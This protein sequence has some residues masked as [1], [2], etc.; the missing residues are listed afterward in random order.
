MST[1]DRFEEIKRLLDSTINEF[2]TLFE[3]AGGFEDSRVGNG[4]SPE[5]IPPE[6]YYL[7]PKPLPELLKIA[8]SRKRTLFKHRVLSFI[9]PR[10]Q[11]VRGS[12]RPRLKLVPFW[13]VRG[14]HE[15]FYFRGNDYKID[16]P[17]DVIAVEVE[18]KIRDLVGSEQ[19]DGQGIGH[20]A[21]R[22]LGRKD[23]TGVK[24]FRLS[25]VTELAYMYDE[26]SIFL[27]AQG[28]EDLEAEAFF[29]R[30]LPLK[31]TTVEELTINYPEMEIAASSIT[32]ED[33]VRKLHALIVKPPTTFSK[34]LSNRFQV[35]ELAQYLM[36]IYAFAFEWRGQ[37]KSIS[38]H[39]Y[40]GGIFQP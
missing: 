3:S 30:P 19:I 23:S 20:L 39:A 26:G 31:K 4:W 1:D 12:E 35:S 14:Y 25:D 18:G 15:C 5:K 8:E 22:L 16:L 7:P 9:K 36:P 2:Q 10:D 27:N 38:V 24:A 34:I 40:T 11:D 37:R 32:K 6:V 33:L 17:Q 21:K 28:K 29:D 13:R